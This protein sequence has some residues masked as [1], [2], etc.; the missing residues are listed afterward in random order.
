MGALPPLAAAAG[1]G[2]AATGGVDF[3][4]D[5]ELALGSEASGSATGGGLDLGAGGG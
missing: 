3:V 1:A 4:F 5:L 2:D